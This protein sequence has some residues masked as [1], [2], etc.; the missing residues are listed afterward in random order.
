M[1]V[2]RDRVYLEGVLL[3][4][5]NFSEGRDSGVIARVVEAF[6]RGGGVLDVHS[7]AVHNRSV[8]TLCGEPGALVPVLREGAQAAVDSID[9][10]GHEGAHPCVGALDVCPV[11]WLSPDD[12][13]RAVEEAEQIGARIAKEL[14]VPVF[15][16]GEMA[17]GQERRERAFFRRGGLPELSRRMEAGELRPDVGPS[18]PHAHAG[19]TLVTARPPLAAFNLELDTGDLAVGAELAAALRESGAGLPGVRA[20]AIPLEGGRTQLSTNV[21]DPLTV[22]LARLVGEAQ[23]FAE[24]TGARVIATELIGLVP[25]AAMQGFPKELLPAGFDPALHL[26]EPRLASLEA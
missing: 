21:H 17:T 6:A 14:G 20:I 3:A 19:A 9:M 2:R 23:R 4:V 11:V 1:T 22:P 15:F 25:E 12:R 8:V 26:I 7:D 16:Y 18:R 10:S 24:R 5:P 13:D